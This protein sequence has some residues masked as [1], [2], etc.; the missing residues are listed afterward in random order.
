MSINAKR[1]AEKC[2]AGRIARAEK[3]EPGVALTP[4]GRHFD[5]ETRKWSVDGKAKKLAEEVA[6]KYLQGGKSFKA[7]SREYGKTPAWSYK[8][9]FEQSGETWVQHFHSKLTNIHRDIASKIPPLL[10][11]KLL[12]RIKARAFDKRWKDYGVR[13][14]PYL[15]SRLVFDARTKYALTGTTYPH[16]GYSYYAPYRDKGLKIRADLLEKDVI[17]KLF[18]FMGGSKNLFEI[19]FPKPE[20]KMLEELEGKRNALQDELQSIDRQRNNLSAAIQRFERED[21]ASFFKR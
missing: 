18:D 11:Q 17:E 4:F 12:N 21:V 5:K 3:G 20:R 15:F 6:E 1:Q 16:N 2:R 8:L 14:H 7:I 13:K 9:L 19:M 10:P